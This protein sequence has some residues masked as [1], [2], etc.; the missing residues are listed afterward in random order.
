MNT[1]IQTLFSYS[2]HDISKIEISNPIF[3]SI[4][5]ISILTLAYLFPKKTNENE[6]ILSKD[7]TKQ[8]KGIAIILI[9]F[10]HLCR[11]TIS[12]PKD[13]MVF[14]DSGTLG[15]SLFLFFSGYGLT[16]SSKK[17]LSSNFWSKKFFRLIVPFII[18]QIAWIICNETLLG[19]NYSFFDILLF[20]FGLKVID[21]NY[22]YIPYLLSWYVI[23][24]YSKRMTESKQG[25]LLP[26]FLFSIT[27]C[28][29]GENSNGGFT[30]FAFPLG[31][32]VSIYKNNSFLY[33]CNRWYEKY[34]IRILFSLFAGYIF[35][36]FASTYKNYNTEIVLLTLVSTILIFSFLQKNKFNPYNLTLF[37]IVTISTSRYADNFST[38]FRSLS[39]AMILIF[40]L[41]FLKITCSKNISIIYNKIGEISF[42][43]YLVHGAFMY[44]YDFILFKFPIYFSVIFYLV[45]IFSI[46]Y[47][48]HL[49]F[50]KIYLLATSRFMTKY[51]H[52]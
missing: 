29:F 5:I 52:G 43:L 14:Y 8:I 50:S 27:I 46:S 16:E 45:F 21:R 36:Y 18:M 3:F 40:F 49:L 48:L 35:F 39:S 13:L 33:A 30:A 28:L 42:E 47:L 9:L 23:F 32:M 17:T 26:L 10:H 19:E 24:F 31:A 2:N 15:I 22:W 4:E 1:L 34:T 6:N 44:S 38:L 37:Y 20:T 12:N 51:E 11:H 7:C 41:L 25:F